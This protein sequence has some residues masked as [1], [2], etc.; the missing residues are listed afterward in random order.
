[1][2]WGSLQSALLIIAV[3]LRVHSGRS[4]C[5]TDPP[6][7]PDSLTR[8]SITSNTN[9][10]L[11]AGSFSLSRW[12]TNVATAG[13]FCTLCDNN[14]SVPHRFAVE[15][16]EALLSA[17][18]LMN[19]V[20]DDSEQVGPLGYRIFDTC[21]NSDVASRCVKAQ[22]NRYRREK[23]LTVALATIVGP[24]YQ[25]HSPASM[26]DDE[27]VDLSHALIDADPPSSTG[28]LSLMDIPFP[29]SQDVEDV[30]VSGIG[31]RFVM[32]QQTCELQASAAVDFLAH[33]GWEN[34]VI[35]ASGDFCGGASLMQFRDHIDSKND[36]HFK[37]WDL[38]ARLN[39]IE[40]TLI[41]EIMSRSYQITLDAKI[42][43]FVQSFV[44][45][46]PCALLIK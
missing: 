24:Y 16:A 4:Q 13:P 40:L 35:V 37:V 46:Q 41:Q 44:K 5:F 10:V 36:R 6:N 3:T 20:T 34:V 18:D 26:S 19:S 38:A 45:Q 11:V 29:Y 32:L 43:V 2:V 14:D 21:G 12:D 39:D 28:L 7:C 31:E 15:Q 8:A 27:L 23:L 33:E 22:L 17:V 9:L 30:H 1:M 42:I 25:K